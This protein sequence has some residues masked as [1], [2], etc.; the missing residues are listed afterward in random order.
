MRDVTVWLHPL[1]RGPRCF[2]NSANHSV[3]GRWVR[4]SSIPGPAE[5]RFI[6]IWLRYRDT[7]S[8][9]SPYTPFRGGSMKMRRVSMLP[10]ASEVIA[11]WPAIDLTW[12][13]QSVLHETFLVELRR[14]QF[15]Y[16]PPH[17]P[18]LAPF[19]SDHWAPVGR[20]RRWNASRRHPH[21]RFSRRRIR[22]YLSTRAALRVRHVRWI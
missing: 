5:S 3:L 21:L 9:H 11:L 14:E 10:F 22:L 4:E 19:S 12:R 13:H 18:L 7:V 16:P 15:D 17:S 8:L 6:G 20:V 2:P 1:S